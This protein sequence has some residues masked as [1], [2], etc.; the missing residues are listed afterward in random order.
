M[1]GRIQPV[2]A[3]RPRDAADDMLVRAIS[4]SVRYAT[5]T[6]LRPTYSA[7][8]VC[9][10]SVVV[11]DGHGERGAAVTG[12][13]ETGRPRAEEAGGGATSERDAKA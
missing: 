12:W 7:P 13:L 10:H 8:R 4:T 9:T 3:L 1:M 5:T 2:G 11:A 6:A